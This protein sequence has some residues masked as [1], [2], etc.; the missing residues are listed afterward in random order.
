MVH[1]YVKGPIT[2]LFPHPS[3]LSVMVLTVFIA[4]L[5]VKESLK[6]EGTADEMVI[7]EPAGN[8]LIILSIIL[9]PLFVF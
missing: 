4:A 9:V 6:V 8:Y 7:F 3:V 5:R 1:L 2:P